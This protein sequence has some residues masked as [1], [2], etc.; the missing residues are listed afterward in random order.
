VTATNA[1]DVAARVHLRGAPTR[2][3]EVA[4]AA[5]GVLTLLIRLAMH[6]RSFDLFG[7]EVI[8]ADLGRSVVSGGFPQ[9]RGYIFFLHGPAFFYLEAGW[10]HLLG[11]PHTLL[12]WIDQMRALNAIFAAATAAVVV[13]LAARASSLRAAVAAGLLFALE[14]FC[15]RQNDRV[16]LETS[17]MLWVLLGYLVLVP[18]IENPSSSRGRLRAVAVGL[19][20]GCAALTKDEG[21]LLT[22]IPLLAAAALRWGPRRALIFLTVGTTVASYAAYVALIAANGYAGT[23]WEAKTSGVQRML[24]LVQVTGFHSSKGISLSARLLSEANYFATT[25][26]ILILAVPALVIVIRRGGRLPRILGLMYC[27]AALALAYAVFL[28]TLEEQELYLLVVPSV[29]IIPM[30]ASMLLSTSPSPRRHAMAW[31]PRGAA[32]AIVALT[33]GLSVN[34]ATCAQWLWQPDDGFARL[35]SYMAAHVPPGTSITDAAMGQV[36]DVGET[37]LA[38]YG[39]YVGFWVTPATR[40]RY[41]VRYVLVPWSEVNQGYSYLSASQ[42]RQLVGSG[43]LVFSFR[44]RT[45]GDLALYRLPPP[46]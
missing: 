2:A 14:P 12:G 23:F 8:Y 18:L 24:G 27:A 22:V 5:I 6:S 11:T 45:F 21:A 30:A 41:R 46:R 33:L 20:F 7:D 1:R 29:L 15:I 39:Y 26:L 13:L 9:Y 17:M 43:N 4:A 28:G 42:V 10:A 38:D 34:L 36:G 44:G 35:L 32:I 19:L 25:Y 40:S 31:R 3:I 37:T 16:I